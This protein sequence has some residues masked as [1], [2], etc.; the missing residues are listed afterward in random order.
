M[1]VDK[2]FKRAEGLWTQAII[3][4][5]GGKKSIYVSRNETSIYFS[6]I[7]KYA[8]EKSIP[9]NQTLLSRIQTKIR[10]KLYLQHS[11]NCIPDTGRIL[12]YTYTLYMGY[13]KYLHHYKNI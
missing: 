8:N 9:L 4:I 6:A 7:A 2:T 11:T 10:K 1:Y 12:P 13:E 3:N 5:S